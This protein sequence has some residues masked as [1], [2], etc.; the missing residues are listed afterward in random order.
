MRIS[1]DSWVYRCTHGY[2]N[3]V[4]EVRRECD[5]VCQIDVR[6]AAGGERPKRFDSLT[7]VDDSPIDL[8]SWL[9][10]YAL[11]WYR[12]LCGAIMYE[13][14]MDGFNSRGVQ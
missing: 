7:V 12:G 4:F 11:R 5:R 14:M 2:S 9:Y 10:L 8:E 3:W 13:N 1:R 6:M